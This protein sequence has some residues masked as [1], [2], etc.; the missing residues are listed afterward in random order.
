MWEETN[1]L[2]RNVD[3]QGVVGGGGGGG[4]S[5]PFKKVLILTGRTIVLCG[6]YTVQLL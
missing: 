5:L 4:F 6:I 2:S 3:F 1:K